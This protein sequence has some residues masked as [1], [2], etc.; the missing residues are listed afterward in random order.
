MLAPELSVPDSPLAPDDGAGWPGVGILLAPDDVSPPQPVLGAAPLPGAVVVL[1]GPPGI[2]TVWPE[3]GMPL[4]PEDVPL[5]APLSG[6]P[7]TTMPWP[8][9]VAPAPPPPGGISEP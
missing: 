4:E 6:P 8:W 1:P 7:G 9:P 2:G 3:P 5:A